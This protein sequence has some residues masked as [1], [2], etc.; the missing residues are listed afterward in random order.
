[1]KLKLS[2]LEETSA[3]K[4]KVYNEEVAILDES[5]NFNWTK[6]HW[7]T[8]YLVFYLYTVFSTE[9]VTFGLFIYREAVLRVTSSDCE[10]KLNEARRLVRIWNMS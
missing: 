6:K 4:M 10:H 9:I 3:E 1:M 2:R 8:E 7:I 5:L